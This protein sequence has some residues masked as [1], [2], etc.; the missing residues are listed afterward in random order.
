M[1]RFFITEI[2]VYSD[3]NVFTL[4]C[5]V[6]MERIIGEETSVLLHWLGA[7]IHI[8]NKGLNG[9]ILYKHQDYY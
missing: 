9:I 3:L 1:L 8:W 2:F 4:L 6:M 5:K 7:K